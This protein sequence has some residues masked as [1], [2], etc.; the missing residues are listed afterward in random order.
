MKKYVLIALIVITGVGLISYPY[1]ASYLSARHASTVVKDYH[2]EV[3]KLDPALIASMLEK[4]RVYNDALAGDPVHDPFIPGSGIVR[5]QNYASILDL[6]GGV[7]GSLSIPAIR[8]DLPIYHGASDA[9]LRKGVG[10]IEGTSF[11]IG[12]KRTHAVLT[13]HTGVSNAR[14]FTDLVT[15]KKGDTF[16]IHVLDKTL[17]YQVD[18]IEVV[19]PSETED[20]RLV[21]DKDYV[22]LVT[23]TPYGINSHRLFVR[24]VRVGYT[25][26]L[27]KAAAAQKKGLSQEQRMVITAAAITGSIMALLIL[28]TA[29]FRGRHD[30]RAKHY[31]PQH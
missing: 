14:L 22:T 18:R 29:L 25:P 12:G 17:A 19:L 24:G 16:F 28:L 27:E 20:L 4:A 30:K 26:E 6:G 5:D 31:Q 10:H 11:P 15:L 8:V 13:G 1:V 9:V 3:E 7:M 23:C 2:Q 21:P